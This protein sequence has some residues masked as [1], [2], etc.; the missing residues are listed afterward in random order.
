MKE[1]EF[2]RFVHR[3]D[4]DFGSKLN[5]AK[6]VEGFYRASH[7]KSFKRKSTHNGVFFL[8]DSVCFKDQCS[9]SGIM[10]AFSDA[11]IASEFIAQLLDQRVEPEVARLHF[12]LKREFDRKDYFELA[13]DMAKMNPPCE[14][15]VETHK[16]AALD[17]GAASG[18]VTAIADS[19]RLN[20]ISDF[21]LGESIM[22]PLRETYYEPVHC[23]FA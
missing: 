8:G 12:T 21:A 7:L 9:A 5:N 4:P 3:M 11:E 1:A 6:L 14:E 23:A 16:A 17:P 13:C 22:Q 18:F 20:E 19:N 2:R 10:H 15:D